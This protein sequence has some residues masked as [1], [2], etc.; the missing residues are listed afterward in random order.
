MIFGF[1]GKFRIDLG[2]QKNCIHFFRDEKITKKI[3]HLVTFEVLLNLYKELKHSL[4][5]RTSPAGHG[6]PQ[7][8][9]E[10]SGNV[11]DAPHSLF[12]T[13]PV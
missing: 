4:Y 13:M 7:A 9:R 11:P 2:V 1:F 6:T 8:S 3:Q 10:C 5:T 12:M